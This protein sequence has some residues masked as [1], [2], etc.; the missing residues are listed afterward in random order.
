VTSKPIQ[1]GKSMCM[2]QLDFCNDKTE[3]L[4]REHIDLPGEIA[5]GQLITPLLDDRAFPES[6]ERFSLEGR[7]SVFQLQPTEF[8][9]PGF[10]GERCGAVVAYSYPHGRLV[11]QGQIGLPDV[12]VPSCDLPPVIFT[13]E[14][15]A[16]DFDTHGPSQCRLDAEKLIVTVS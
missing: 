1:G 6:N 3:V 11:A 8:G 2:A 14:E 16:F 12:R 10:H 9:R 5:T 13:D 4:A 15:P 7:N